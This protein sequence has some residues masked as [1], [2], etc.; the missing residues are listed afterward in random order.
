MGD[1]DHGCSQL[2]CQA[3]Q[4]A[5]HAGGGLGVEVAGG[6]VGQHAAGPCDQRAGQCH[7][8]AF[9]ARQLA[10]SMLTALGQA[11]QPQHLTSRLLSF[12]TGPPTDQQRHGH[13][14]DGGELA[15]QVVELV[16]ETQLVIAQLPPGRF[17]KRIQ[18]LAGHGHPAGIGLIQPAQQV[19]QRALARA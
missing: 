13:V 12:T 10:G 1:D 17:R 18:A 9:T 19:Q 15:Q 6:L 4:Q 11:D 3:M 5:E 8:L 7:P 16:D 2:T 14:L